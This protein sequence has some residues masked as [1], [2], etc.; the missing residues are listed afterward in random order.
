[1]DHSTYSQSTEFPFDSF[2]RFEPKGRLTFSSGE[3]L[4]T[5]FNLDC[6]HCQESAI[7]LGDLKRKKIISPNSMYY[8]LKKDQR[9]SNTLNQ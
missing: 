9:L 2:T 6:E 8:I 5:V 4:V 7:E 3:N 1:M